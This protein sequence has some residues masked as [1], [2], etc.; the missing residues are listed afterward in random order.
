MLAA[1]HHRAQSVDQG[2]LRCIGRRFRAVGLGHVALEVDALDVVLGQTAN[3]VEIGQAIDQTCVQRLGGQIGAVVDQASGLCDRHLAAV[4]DR[5]GELVAPGRQQ[6][7]Q[8]AADRGGHGIAGQG[9]DGALVFLALAEAPG[10]AQTG[11]RLTHVGLFQQEPC[12]VQTAGRLQ[13]H[14]VRC[15]REVVVQGAVTAL[16]EALGEAEHHL[17]VRPEGNQSVAQLLHLCDVDCAGAQTQEDTLH[18]RVLA[19]ILD[20]CNQFGE[21]PGSSEGRCLEA[22]LA[23]LHDTRRDVEF[24]HHGVRQFAFGGLQANSLVE[25]LGSF[26]PGEHADQ[27]D[28]DHQQA[29]AGQKTDDGFQQKEDDADHAAALRSVAGSGG[30]GPRTDAKRHGTRGSASCPYLKRHGSTC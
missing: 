17:V 21:L 27:H 10:D 4:G 7:V 6:A 1:Q 29:D 8:V 5:A 12:E 23:A 25:G 11:Q 22:A 2:D 20:R 18:S 30:L 3:F 9:V 16:A 15:G 24:Q 19:G 28:H 26:A 13:P 14:F